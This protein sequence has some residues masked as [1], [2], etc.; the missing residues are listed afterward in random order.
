MRIVG[1]Q[2]RDVGYVACTDIE[3]LDG[4]TEEFG[5]NHGRQSVRLS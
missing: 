4:L 2:S 1:K 5:F 3:F